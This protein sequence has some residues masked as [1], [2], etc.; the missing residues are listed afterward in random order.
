MIIGM[1]V[2]VL[3]SIS[4]QVMTL[5]PFFLYALLGSCKTGSATCLIYGLSFGYLYTVFPIVGLASIVYL[6]YWWLGSF[7]I[8][9]GGMGIAIY[10]LICMNINSYFT[11][12]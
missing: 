7:G 11:I 9:M 6:W 8:A 10:V 12:V 1:T 5:H 3:I 4:S 2:S